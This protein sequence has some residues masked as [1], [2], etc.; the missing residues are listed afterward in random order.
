[1][2]SEHELKQLFEGMEPSEQELAAY[3]FR[4]AATLESRPR[5]SWRG[6]VW[7][8]AGGPLLASLAAVVWLVAV[9]PSLSQQTLEEVEALVASTSDVEGLR[10][11]AERLEQ[12]GPGLERHNAT[13]VLVLTQ[14]EGKALE[15]AA[16][17][18][19]SDPRPELR[20]FYLE[21]LL[22]YAESFELNA[23]K[24]EELMEDEDDEV[25]FDLYARLLRM[26]ERT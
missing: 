11:R 26:A 9:P 24:I 14:P 2:A 23:E 8:A 17:G 20:S 12:R 25:C 21:Y 5:R 6:W 15:A 18:V 16:R 4:L 22:D 1:M 13:L 10:R 7:L 3:R 19:V